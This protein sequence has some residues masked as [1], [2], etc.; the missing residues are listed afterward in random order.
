L[1]PQKYNDLAR[2]ERI[3]PQ[4]S[5]IPSGNDERRKNFRIGADLA[6]QKAR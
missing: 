6:D 4:G 3:L 2:N 1:T 5:R